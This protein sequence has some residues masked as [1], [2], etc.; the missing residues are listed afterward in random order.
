MSENKSMMIDE[1][2]RKYNT[3]SS[4][5]LKKELVNGVIKRSYIPYAEKYAIC[6]GIIKSCYFKDGVIHIDSVSE[7]MLYCL[8]IVENYT[9]LIIDYNKSVDEFDKLNKENL[10]TIIVNSL[11]KQEQEEMRMVLDMVEKDVIA[12]NYEIHSFISFQVSR[13]GNIIGTLCN[14]GLLTLNE[15]L[16]DG[17]VQSNIVSIKDKIKG[18]IDKI[19]HSK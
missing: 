5:R 7:Y 19:F 1:F 11:P 18:G 4:D 15:Y 2:I 10:I 13:F 8:K 16:S 3:M 14:S 12:N 9:Y 6:N 17:N